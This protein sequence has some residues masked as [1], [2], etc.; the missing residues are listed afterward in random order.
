MKIEEKKVEEPAKPISKVYVR[1]ISDDDLYSSNTISKESVPEPVVVKKEEPK[2]VV[3]EVKVEPP[4]AQKN[5][6]DEKEHDFKTKQEVLQGLLDLVGVDGD[7]LDFVRKNYKQGIE[8]SIN[9]W[10]ESH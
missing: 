8:G 3:V 4:K 6:L 2:P 1:E 7:Y 5:K 10:F 9:L